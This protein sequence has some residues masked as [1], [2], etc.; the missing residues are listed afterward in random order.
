[1]AIRKTVTQ[2]LA[3]IAAALA[4]Q[5]PSLPE[6]ANACQFCK[7]QDPPQCEANW[8]NGR[9]NCGVAYDAKV[10]KDVCSTS[11]NICS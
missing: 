9:D 7:S 4:I 10:G 3:L 2:V 8:P 6:S 5:R 1:M 11:G